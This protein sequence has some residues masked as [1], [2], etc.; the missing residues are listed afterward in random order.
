MHFQN[1]YYPEFGFVFGDVLP[2][3]IIMSALLLKYQTMDAGSRRISGHVYFQNTFILTDTLYHYVR[4]RDDTNCCL[5]YISSC[6]SSWKWAI[7]EFCAF[8]E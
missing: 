1:Q 4:A 6:G 8:V 7:G 3:P 2:I 5:S